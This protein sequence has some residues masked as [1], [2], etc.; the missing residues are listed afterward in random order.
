MNSPKHDT[1]PTGNQAIYYQWLGGSS[2]RGAGKLAFQE[3]VLLAHWWCLL[4]AGPPRA[5]ASTK[6]QSL[7]PS[8]TLLR[9]GFSCTVPTS[10]PHQRLRLMGQGLGISTVMN[11][12]P[13]SA[14]F[15][16]KLTISIIFA[17]RS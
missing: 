16:R 1:P 5:R 4:V 8:R 6:K 11:K 9:T 14:I 17:C 7:C 15:F 13:S 12:K 3:V 10:F 2:L